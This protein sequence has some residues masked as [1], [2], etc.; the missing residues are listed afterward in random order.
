MDYEAESWK[1]EDPELEQENVKLITEKC[2]PK[3]I[4]EKSLKKIKK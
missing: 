2:F 4:L 3:K 1:W